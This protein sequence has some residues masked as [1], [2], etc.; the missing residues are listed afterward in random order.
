MVTV[1]PTEVDVGRTNKASVDEFRVSGY[2]DQEGFLIFD[3]HT[4]SLRYTLDDSKR[5]AISE[6]RKRETVPFIAESPAV[7][8]GRWRKNHPNTVVVLGSRRRIE[9]RKNDR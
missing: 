3:R 7:T 6:P 2:A 5:T 1:H 9:N 8:L 4:E